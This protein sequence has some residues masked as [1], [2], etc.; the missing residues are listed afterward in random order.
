MKIQQCFLELRLKMSG[1][2]FLRHTVYA[3]SHRNH[4]KL[5][6]QAHSAAIVSFS[7]DGSCEVVKSG[8]VQVRLFE[9][10]VIPAAAVSDHQH[11]CSY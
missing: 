4:V 7:E 10:S 9:K 5:Y 1:M 11:P 6:V 2:F 3:E 8:I